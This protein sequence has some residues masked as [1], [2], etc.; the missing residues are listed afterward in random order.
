MDVISP[1]QETYLETI[2][3]LSTSRGEAHTTEIAEKMGVSKPSVTG[4]L[5]N[6][7][8]RGLIS[9]QPY[10]PI[11]LTSEGQELA[12]SI[13]ERHTVLRTFLKRVLGIPEE[14][15]E[16]NAGTLEHHISPLVQA[17]LV[18]YIQFVETCVEQRF[19]WR[20]ESG[21]TCFGCGTD[22]ENCDS[23]ARNKD[24]DN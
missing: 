7:S 16:K 2:Y 9:Y 15:A 22:C 5:R 18:A 20:D 19:E 3:L 10:R 12:E 21:F 1:S 11:Q 17:R 14:I 13:H 6:L 8:D 24:G 23:N 4:A